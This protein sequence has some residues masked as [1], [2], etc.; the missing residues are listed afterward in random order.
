MDCFFPKLFRAFPKSVSIVGSGGKTTLLFLLT[1]EARHLGLRT[2]VCT[3]THIMPPDTSPDWVL[4][5]HEDGSTSEDTMERC[6]RVLREGRSP[7]CG[8]RAKEGKLGPPPEEVLTFLRA[9]TDVLL[10]ETDGSRHLP[11]KYPN[12]TEPVLLPGTELVIAVAGLGA[13]GT[14]LLACCHRFPLAMERMG[15]SQNAVASPETIAGLL[16]SGYARFAPLVVLNQ[17]D[18]P[19]RFRAGEET[20]GILRGLGLEKTVTT[21]LRKYAPEGGI[22]S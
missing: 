16:F 2:A 20:A 8:V 14:P 19:E 9:N 7:V 21:A 13:L 3:T 18:T 17:A 1:R 12:G 6:G 4:I 22:Q 5:I 15:L 11:L 10:A